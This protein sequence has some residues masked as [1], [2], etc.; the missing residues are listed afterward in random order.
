MLYGDAVPNCTSLS[1]WVITKRCPFTTVLGSEREL[2]KIN[3]PVNLCL[4]LTYAL[5]PKPHVSFILAPLV[6]GCLKQP[7][8]GCSVWMSWHLCPNKLVSEMAQMASFSTWGRGLDKIALKC[9]LTLFFSS[10]FVILEKNKICQNSD[11]IY[12]KSLTKKDIYLPSTQRDPKMSHPNL[13]H[14]KSE[15]LKIMH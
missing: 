1:E 4:A 2:F 9:H 3:K 12:S 6:S 7:R 11:E 10:S 8:R 5:C 15:P 14:G 13:Q